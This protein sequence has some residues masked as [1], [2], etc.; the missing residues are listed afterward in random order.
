MQ[1]MQTEPG[2]VCHWLRAGDEIFPAMLAAIDAA[3]PIG[4]PGN[5]YF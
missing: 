3:S 4:L 2:S 5:L 1:P